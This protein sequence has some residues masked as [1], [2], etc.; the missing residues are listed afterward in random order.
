MT[1]VLPFL[2][3]CAQPD[4]Q[5]GNPSRDA[6]YVTIPEEQ[7]MRSVPVFG[8]TLESAPGIDGFISADPEGNRLVRIV[9][10]AVT[11]L[12]LGSNARPFRIHVEDVTAWATL[13]G[14]GEL[15]EVDLPTMQV[16]WRTR[17]C[18]EPR[19]VT[20]SQEGPL[21]V[22]CADGPIAEV[23]DTTGE[24]IRSR[25][26]ATDLRDIVAVGDE[27]FVSRFTSA[28]VLVVD[29]ALLIAME[30]RVLHDHGRVAWRM[31]AD[32][33]DAS[34]VAVLH[35]LATLAVLVL[36]PDPPATYYPTGPTATGCGRLHET[37]VTRDTTLEG[38]TTSRGLDQVR[39]ATDFAFGP[40][41][42]VAFVST[43]AEPGTASVVEFV[44]GL[45]TL[46]AGEDS[47]VSGEAIDVPLSGRAAALA[48]DAWGQLFVQSASPFAVVRVDD[49]TTLTATRGDAT[50]SSAQL[51][52]TAVTGSGV[53]CANCHPEGLE[54][55]NVWTF[56]EP[57]G[58]TMLRRTM[59][60]AGML[61]SREPYHWDGHLADPDALMADTYTL[62]MGGG[63]VEPDVPDA[64]FDWLDD[65]RPV[66]GIPLVTPDV[67][68]R[69]R[70]AF[71][72]AE[73][74]VCH[75]GPAFTNNEVWHALRVGTDPVKTPTLLGVGTRAPLLHDGCAAT[76]EERFLPPCDDGNDRHGK[77][78]ALPPGDLDALI[79]YLRSL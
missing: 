60:L 44:N 43:A 29:P 76:L 17:V 71:L 10:D 1:G 50:T 12:D 7:L 42:S 48:Y 49:E 34:G 72:L 37:V 14:S 55:G 19:G 68:E 20:R 66:R 57:D 8:G 9:G 30:E 78:S 62:R 77:L 35:Q 79:A 67:V 38:T 52:H 13:R 59:P 56:K 63:A 4:A 32:P 23:D 73:C 65:L 58:A 54:D 6:P 47:C 40:G 27:L 26:V 45:T 18:G 64:L 11:T 22:A 41:R 69:G 5:Q 31:R 3:G 15:V 16:T 33:L 28:T 2:A 70:N 75:V 24:L 46:W 61:R 51:F 36:A 39:M 53:A 74:G 21:V 25:F